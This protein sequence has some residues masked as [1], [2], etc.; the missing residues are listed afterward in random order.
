M[1]TP[2]LGRSLIPLPGES[3]PGFILRLSCR[4]QLPPARL[5]AL[6]G[7][8][9]AGHSGA[10]APAS[11]LTKIPEPAGRTFAHMTRLTTEKVAQ[12]GLACLQERYPLPA[13]AAKNA[14]TVPLSGL[15]VFAP[16][17]RYCP[18]CLAGDGSP[19]QGA[20]GGPW[21][22]IWHLPVVF[23]CTLH[24]RLLEDRCPECGQVTH[25]HHPGAPALMLPAMRAAA[26]HP[27]QCRTVLD[28][29]R[30][31]TLPACCGRRLDRTPALRPADPELITLQHKILGLL[32]PRGPA[33]TLSAARPAAPARYF[34]DLQAL[35]LLACSTWPAIRHLSPSQETAEAIDRH[36]E[37]L[38]QRTA[39]RQSRSRSSK[40]R[41]TSGP[42]PTDAAASGG[43]AHIADRI[44]LSGGPGEVR[45]H[46]RPLLPASTRQA[47]R[48][49]WGL[50]V[51]RSTTPCSEG[52]QAAYTPLLR[53]FT[54]I[55]GQ[56]QARRDAVVRPQ[57]WGPEHIPAF[58]PKDWYDRHFRPLDGV[59]PMLAR[60]TAALRLV[61]MVV[62]GSLSEAAGLLGIAA[63]DSTWL[64]KSRIYSG[65]GQVHSNARKQPD[66]LAFEAAL[67]ALAAEL[68][69][70]ST[71]RINYQQRRRA[72]ETWS[73]DEDTWNDLASRL[74]PVPGP[75]RPDLGD[76]K[77]QIASIYAWVQ[78]TS[79][80]HC[81]APRPIEAAQPPEIR[82]S[83]KLR[84]NTIWHLMQSSRPRPHYTSLKTELNTLATS[85]A[86]TIDAPRQ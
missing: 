14:A 76:R 72:L 32:E 3:L 6:T 80:E 62:G 73:I 40:V 10:R 27:C 12:L 57:H 25:S 54:K 37:A 5:A 41:A 34:T 68:D 35:A 7:L 18:D 50:R 67:Q 31:R 15:P 84:R 81:F 83:W 4:L 85:L 38:R 21:R 36:V 48:T 56:P 75:Q 63:T 9:P 53:G 60:R 70:P 51:S 8:V 43:L 82:Q 39:G 20:F 79:G 28:A 65:A 49:A 19:I 23:A 33:H 77:R 26:L 1:P 44:L 45:E 74:P 58:L 78:V 29:G 16:A 59:N 47:G 86:R 22:K 61:Q 64:R 17:T 66:P 30:G 42:P 55:G 69:E 52:L 13:G 46:L 24:R 71:P 2:P 11:L